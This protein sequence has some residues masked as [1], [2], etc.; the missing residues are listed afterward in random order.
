MQAGSSLSCRTH[1]RGGRL[2]ARAKKDRSKVPTFLR[3]CSFGCRSLSTTI[4][5]TALIR[6]G[7]ISL[8][9]TT[10]AVHTETGQSRAKVLKLDVCSTETNVNVRLQG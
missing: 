3:T 1:G 7:P 4:G 5:Y 9:V 2:G 10:R 8:V 6:S